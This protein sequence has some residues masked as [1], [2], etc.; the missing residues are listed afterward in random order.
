M[1]L[2]QAKIPRE[3]SCGGFFAKQGIWNL[4]IRMRCRLLTLCFVCSLAFIS[5]GQTGQPLAD[6]QPGQLDIHHINTGAGNAT[7]AVLPDGTTLLIDA[8]SVNPLDWRTNQPRNLPIK[9]NKSRLA[10]E[11]IARYVRNVLRFQK[12]PAIDYAIIT[13]FHDDHM[14]SP[15]NLTKR[16][17]EGYVLTG[18]TEVAEHIPIRTILDRGWPDYRYPRPFD[19]DSM[20]INYR[21]FLDNK[22]QKKELVAERF[23][24]GRND[25]ITLKKQPDLYKSTFEI[26]NVAVNGEIW[27]GSD[28][29]TRALFPDLATL[30]AAQYP[31]ENMCS[32][33]LTIRYGNFDYFS[34]GDIYGILQFGEPAWHDVETPLAQVVGLVDVQL[35]NH[36]GYKDSENGSLLSRLRPRVLVVPA[37]ASSHA[38]RSVL[39]RIYSKELYPGERDVFV[40]NL[41]DETKALISDYLPQFK[42]TSGHV[43]VR[44]DAG[45]KTY[46]I[47]VVDDNTETLT[48]KSVHGPY[49][50]N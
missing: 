15:L 11:W 36:H 50:A 31:N 4:L 43:V 14:G 35:L 21:Q 17:S 23:R 19:S 34:G 28:S 16:A 29:L 25:Q 37:W 32:I 6:W 44:V 45:G 39:E 5:W 3:I 27:T 7:F 30:T 24:A 38:D 33:A 18:I 2:I 40:T 42:S 48:V 12:Q 26:R 46:R 47:F 41:L 8:G 1:R 20:V 13:H 49:Q 9:P 22:I 10:G